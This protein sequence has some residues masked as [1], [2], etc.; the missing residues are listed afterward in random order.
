MGGGLY[1]VLCVLVAIW[2]ANRGRS[3]LRWFLIGLVIS[4]LLAGIFVWVLKNLDRSIMDGEI[5]DGTH[6]RCP[7]CRVF[8][9]QI[10]EA[11]KKQVFN[12]YL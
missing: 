7:D 2:A 8:K 11:F 1:L 10:H 3:G 4:P 6:V 12:C 5:S 9:L